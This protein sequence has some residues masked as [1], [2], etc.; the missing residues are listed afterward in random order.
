[1]SY[2]KVNIVGQVS[3]EWLR[4]PQSY[5]YYVGNES[6]GDDNGYPHNAK[7]MVED[8]VSVALKED[9]SIKWDKYDINK[10]G[11]DALFV[12]HAGPGAEV[13][14]TAAQRAKH[15]G[16]HKW[17]V[18]R[19]VNVT[20]KTRVVQY[21]TVPEDGLLGV[22]AH[23]T[24]HLVFGWPD[25]YDACTSPDRTAALGDW[26]LMAGA[27]WNGGGLTPAYPSAWCRHVQGW[28]NTTVLK[29]TRK[30]QVP[31]ADGSKKVFLLRIKDRSNEYF[32]LEGRK[33]SKFDEFVPG[34]GLLVYHVDEGQENNCEVDHLSVGVVQADGQRNLQRLG[35]FGNQGDDGDP[36]P[37]SKKRTY[38]NSKGY[39]NSRDYNNKP[40]GIN[41][42][43]IKW[44]GK[45]A[46]ANITSPK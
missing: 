29:G 18:Q 12:I 16:S 34:E 43:S 15:I 44:N 26:C 10:D 39:P 33:K 27:S 7:R 5:S 37:G 2:G 8:A 14:M 6:G 32:M 30:I 40:T 45:V 31:T 13:Q 24:G 36:F 28:T 11:I 46:T 25:L 3:R 19:P 41:I 21:M 4:L 20:D 22:F 17:A 23:E 9:N 1:V 42:R 38:L 35:L